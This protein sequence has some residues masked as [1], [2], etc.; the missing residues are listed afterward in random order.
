MRILLIRPPRIKQA[1]TLGSFMFSEPLG[2]EMVHGALEGD[3]KVRILDMMIE[4]CLERELKDFEPDIAG[5]TSLCIDVGMVRDIASR[6]KSHSREIQVL[7]GGTQ[8]FLNPE[9]FFHQDIDHVF[10][11]TTSEN[12]RGLTDIVSGKESGLVDGVLS[13][14]LGYKDSGRQGRNEYLPPNRKS[15]QKYRNQYSYFGYRPAAIMEL[16][17]GCEKACDFCLRWRIEGARESL[18]DQTLTE[19]DLQSIEEETIMFIDNDLFSDDGK[20]RML[21]SL[22]KKLGISKNYIAYGSVKGIL[23]KR[24]EVR[25]LAELGLKALLVG[26]E[27]FSPEELLDYRKKSTPEDNLEAARFLRSLDIDVW[28]SFMAHPDWDKGDFTEFRK[29]IRALNPQISSINPLTPFPGLPMYEEYKDR[30]LH[31]PE[32]YEKWSF[33]QVIIR[34]SSMSLKNYYWELLKTYLYINISVNKSTEMI[35]KYGFAN[36]ARILKGS[37]GASIK[38]IRLM[39]GD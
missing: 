14:Q 32:E 23:D 31:K 22:I 39:L 6:I 1:I 19:K 29:Y 18:L 8:A 34:P 13:R 5:I 7:V 27:T 9:S 10:K 30:L 36:I 11:Y 17:M 25:D 28:A 3:H 35:R 15:T 24:E 38:Y 2:L 16:G 4:D 37:A 26:Y 12:L 21:I 20:A 33:G